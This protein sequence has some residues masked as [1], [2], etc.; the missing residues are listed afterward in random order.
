MWE[1]GREPSGGLCHGLW[2]AMV[3]CELLGEHRQSSGQ[4]WGTGEGLRYV[5]SSLL[6][7]SENVAKAREEYIFF[8]SKNSPRNHN[9]KIRK[10]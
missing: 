10:L 4:G 6:A 1:V 9:S 2:R 8:P 7:A 3:F 5:T